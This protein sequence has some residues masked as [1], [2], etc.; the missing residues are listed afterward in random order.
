M[1][2]QIRDPVDNDYGQWRSPLWIE[3]RISEALDNNDESS[4]DEEQRTYVNHYKSAHRQ[5]SATWAR[6][7]S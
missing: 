5:T 2:Q 6:D 7:C 4:L 3:N 1:D